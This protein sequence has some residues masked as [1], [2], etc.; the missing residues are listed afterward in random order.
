MG[1][2]ALMMILLALPGVV[3][4][5]DVSVSGSVVDED[6]SVTALAINPGS[7]NG[8]DVISANEPN[9]LRVWIKNNG[10][11]DAGAFDVTMIIGA[12]TQTVNVAGRAAGENTSV[13]FTYA[14]TAIG[15]ISIVTTADSGAVIAESNEANNALTTPSNVYYNGY[16]GKRYTAGNDFTTVNTYTGRDG[17]VYSTGNAPYLGYSPAWTSYSAASLQLRQ[18]QT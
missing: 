1:I 13:D 17:V 2:L 9:T 5:A 14:P 16:K 8:H 12:F 18:V 3:S 15:A 11:L 4:A 6:L 10:G 7:S